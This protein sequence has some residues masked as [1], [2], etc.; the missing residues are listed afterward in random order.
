MDVDYSNPRNHS[1]GIAPKSRDMIEEY[2]KGKKAE[3]HKDVST[4]PAQPLNINSDLAGQQEQEIKVLVSEFH[5]MDRIVKLTRE[6]LGNQ[7][8]NAEID[9]ELQ[10]L[11][12]AL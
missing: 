11:V 5:L 1:S 6:K 2:E 9:K 12:N 8:R 7:R 4:E 3:E 10:R